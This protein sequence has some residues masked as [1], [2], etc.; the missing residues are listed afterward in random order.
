M[1]YA[2][3]NLLQN[4][5]NEL[6]NMQLETHKSLSKGLSILKLFLNDKQDMTLNEIAELSGLNKPT[7]CRIATTLV[8]NGFLTQTGKRG[9]YSLGIIY[10]GFS[11]VIN[12]RLRVRSVALPY[13]AELSKQLKESTIIAYKNN[14]TTDVFTETIHEIYPSNNVLKAVPEDGT[15]MSLYATCLGK[16]ILAEMSNKEFQTYFRK[17]KII[18]FTPNTIIDIDRM[19]EHLIKIRNDGVSYDDEEFSLGVKGV[20]VG[21]KDSEGNIIGAIGVIVPSARLNQEKINIYLPKI[22]RCASKISK[23]MGFVGD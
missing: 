23:E 20:A 4:K 14:W 12:S 5:K 7:A 13:L 8:K 1:C 11:K 9:K 3:S 22:K 2:C 6:Y 19:K 10:L 17:T 16:I 21:L 18:Q 15:G